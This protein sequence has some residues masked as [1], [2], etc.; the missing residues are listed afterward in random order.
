MAERNN[1][2][3][4]NAEATQ[5]LAPNEHVQS[6]WI[7]DEIER[8]KSE[9]RF[10]TLQVR[11]SPHVGGQ[12][13]LDHLTLINFS[14]NDYLGLAADARL[15]AAA[16]GVANQVGWGSAASPLVSGYGVWHAALE[17]RV[18]AFEQTEAALICSTG[19]AANLSVLTALAGKGDVIFS[20]ALNHASIIDGCR[21]SG[22]AIQVYRHRDIRHLEELLSE[23]DSFRRKL[24]VT[25]TLFSM[26]GDIAP[27]REI[28]DLAERFHAMIVIDEAHATGV[29]GER[30]K[31]VAEAMG[32]STRVTA[33][34]GTFSKACG[35]AGGFVAGAQHVMDWIR[36]RGRTYI[37]STAQPEAVAAAS[38]KAID[39]IESES[40]T[41]KQ[42]IEMAANVRN[43]LKSGGF[44]IGNSESQIIPIV[45]GSEAKALG[46]AQALRELGLLVPAIR[47]PTVPEGNVDCES[48]CVHHRDEHLEALIDGLKSVVPCNA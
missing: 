19:Y 41:R 24:I 5:G 1:P 46:A 25:D 2:V 18:A 38:H 21:L 37:F 16:N 12:I 3:E 8:L 13:H 26:D 44:Y 4:T 32:V 14:S 43:R 28:C 10:R 20:D 31:G 27:L 7:F 23:C 48:A 40:Q 42:L 34:V 29:F 47:P 35:S 30:G 22:A 33:K 6:N 39:I 17:R 45:L 11:Q 15:I 36:N 9:Q